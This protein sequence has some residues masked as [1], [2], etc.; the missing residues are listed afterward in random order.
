ML[1]ILFPTIKINLVSQAFLKCYQCS[2]D[3]EENECW[4]EDSIE[5]GR[6]VECEPGQNA[7]A[8]SRGGTRI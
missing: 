2:V 6:V 5:H 1:T 8:K 7:C 3:W 4:K